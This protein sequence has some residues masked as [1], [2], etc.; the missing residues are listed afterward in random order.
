[1]TRCKT[2]GY[3]IEKELAELL[4][5]YRELS[6]S[7]DDVLAFQQEAAR[8]MEVFKAT[9]EQL[10]KILGLD[11][12]AVHANDDK[13]LFARRLREVADELQMYRRMMYQGSTVN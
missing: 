8:A 1:M 11:I 7:R 9:N 10:G 3:D 2:C 13:D 4:N 5:N 6:K 12:D